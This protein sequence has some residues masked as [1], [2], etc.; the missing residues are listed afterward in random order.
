M[1]AGQNVIQLVSLS[2][3]NCDV[4]RANF[5]LHRCS[6]TVSRPGSARTPWRSS[7]RSPRPPSWSYG[8]HFA[9]GG[10]EKGKERQRKEGREGKGKVGKEGREGKGK[11][12]MPISPPRTLNSPPPVPSGVE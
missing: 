4:R 7:Q 12:G 6:K 2:S 5:Q 10:G 8:G 1:P 3:M 11:G 9:A